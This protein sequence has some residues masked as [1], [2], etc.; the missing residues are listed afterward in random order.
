MDN[1]AVIVLHIELDNRVGISPRKFRNGGAL[2]NYF[3]ALVVR[4]G[5]M[6][7][8]HRRAKREKA[9]Q[10]EK[11]H[12]PRLHERL[13]GELNDHGLTELP[14]LCNVFVPSMGVAWKRD[15]AGSWSS[16]PAPV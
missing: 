8:E 9:E 3:L 14:M 6:M 11:R 12:E 1:L 2:K 15:R 4:R 5:T 13:L 16:P 7:S 10:H